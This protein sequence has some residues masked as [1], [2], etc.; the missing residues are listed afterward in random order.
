M[1]RIRSVAVLLVLAIQAAM[2]A[3]IEPPN[4]K[5]HLGVIKSVCLFGVA[6]GAGAE[7]TAAQ[8]A[9]M[10]L[11][12]MKSRIPRLKTSLG[13]TG[14]CEALIV[15]SLDAS[16]SSLDDGTVLGY[17]ASLLLRVDRMA[18]IQATGTNTYV[19]VWSKGMIFAGPKGAQSKQISGDVDQLVTS[20]A[21][22]YY[23]VSNE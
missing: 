12:S 8:L 15:T 17:Y 23:K 11:V 21:A 18:T 4:R 7:V 6:Y 9:D 16:E 19:T 22:D 20:L 1:V 13:E 2:A 14:H 5:A 10:L 3:T